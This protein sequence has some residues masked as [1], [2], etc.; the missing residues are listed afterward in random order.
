ME[1][2]MKLTFLRLIS[3]GIVFAL[4]CDSGSAQN[5]GLDARRVA[6]GGAG[7]TNNSVSNMIEKQQN[8]RAIP[9]P[10]GLIQVVRNR[11]IFDPTHPD[12]D[13]VRALEYAADPMNLTINRDSNAQ[14]NLFITDLID[15]GL[16][17]NRDLNTYR[18][19]KPATQ[20]QAQGLIRPSWGLTI[21]VKGNRESAFHG[22]YV[23]AGP[24]LAIGTALDFDQRLVDVFS[25]S[26]DVYHPNST[27]AIGNVTTGQAAVAITGGYRGRFAVKGLDNVGKGEGV[28]VEANYHYLHGIHYDHGDLTLQLDTDPEGLL[29]MTQASVPL[30]VDRTTSRKG[31]GFSMDV[32]T[33]VVKGPWTVGVGLD[34]IGNRIN[35]SEASGRRYELQNVFSGGD[36]ITA[37]V[38]LADTSIRATLPVR[39]QTNVEYTSSRWTAV[40]E[41][42]KGLHGGDSNGGA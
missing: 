3:V 10:I 41:L 28:Y 21:P 25:S 32:A 15:A 29:T 26:T 34:G 36:F 7:A 20:M 6:L 8:Y 1:A 12:F 35:W 5:L 18:G 42:G 27:Y 40:T 16:N 2:E 13:P 14:Q 22:I 11:Q 30:L 24:Y 39:F 9:I 17:I 37:P 31:H 33:G 23:G 19:F 4:L 38:Q